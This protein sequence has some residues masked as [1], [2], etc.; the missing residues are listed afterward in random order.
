LTCPSNCTTCSSTATGLPA[1]HALLTPTWVMEIAFRA[2]QALLVLLQ[3]HCHLAQ[4][5]LITV[6]LARWLLLIMSALHALL[7][8]I[9]IIIYI[10]FL[11]LQVLLVLL[12]THCHLAWGAPVTVVLAPPLLLVFPALHALLTPI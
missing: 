3:T 1:L 9:Y 6:L 7:M 2:L 8:P 11:A 12:Q 5:A 4:L 10:A